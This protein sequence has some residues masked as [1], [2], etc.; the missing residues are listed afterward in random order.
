MTDKTKVIFRK[1]RDG[2]IDAIFPELPASRNGHDCVAY[3]HIGQH[4]GADYQGVISQ[5]KPAT[6]D[7]YAPLLAELTRIGYTLD[8]V[9]REPRGAY[10]TRRAAALA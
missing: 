1:W 4:S 2:T 10:Q 3:A 6:P 5:T 9:K 7:D 8:V